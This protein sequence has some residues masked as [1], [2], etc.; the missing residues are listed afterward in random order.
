MKTLFI[1]ICL[2]VVVVF[3]L[4]AQ[5]DNHFKYYDVE[6]DGSLSKFTSKLRKKAPEFKITEKRDGYYSIDI[7]SM[8][9]YKVENR[10]VIISCLIDASYELDRVYRITEVYSNVT[11][12]TWDSVKAHLTYFENLLTAIYGEP[13]KQEYLMNE[14][15]KEGSNREIEGFLNEKNIYST[16]W[17]VDSPQEVGIG[18][19]ELSLYP[20]SGQLLILIEYTDT[21]NL[22]GLIFDI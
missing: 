18:E 20:E 15:H 3:N 4:S 12:W 2:T 11:N 19:V 13:T 21:Y 16:L 17:T 14:N 5:N 9:I 8:P 7:A 6:I 22:F 1:G 10:K